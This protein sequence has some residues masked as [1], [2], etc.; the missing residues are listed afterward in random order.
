MNRLIMA[1]LVLAMLPGA[2][3]AQT[4][5]TL[6]PGA[7]VRLLAIGGYTAQG[8]LV[9]LSADSVLL[10]SGDAGEVSLPLGAVRRLEVLRPKSTAWAGAR[11]GAMWGG[12]LGVLI[13]AGAA[14]GSERGIV[15]AGFTFPVLGTGVFGGALVGATLLRGSSWQSVPLPGSSP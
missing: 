12:V 4:R 15:S 10:R 3:R 1:A 14:V 11:R 8:S 13:S 7:R 2:A 5:P 6:E 9:R